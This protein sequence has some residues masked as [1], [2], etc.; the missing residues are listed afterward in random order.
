MGT[1]DLLILLLMMSLR[2][3]QQLQEVTRDMVWNQMKLDSR[4]FC[5][6]YGDDINNNIDTK[7]TY[8]AVI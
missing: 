2:Y 3:R 5:N 6:M 7:N 1:L 8:S 4:F